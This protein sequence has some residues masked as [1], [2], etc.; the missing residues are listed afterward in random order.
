MGTAEAFPSIRD[1]TSHISFVRGERRLS[2]KQRLLKDLTMTDKADLPAQRLN[3]TCET[4]HSLV[5]SHILATSSLRGYAD[6]EVVSLM[7]RTKS[8][9]FSD[10]TEQS[11]AAFLGP[12]PLVQILF[13][14]TA[15]KCHDSGADL[16]Q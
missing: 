3:L 1:N 15:T 11:M 6:L 12:F 9:M 13:G 2:V 10:T 5:L 4:I 14:R 16:S 7:S 8:V